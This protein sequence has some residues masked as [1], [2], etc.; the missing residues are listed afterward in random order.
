MTRH[1]KIATTG[2]WRQ[3]GVRYFC[4]SL[5]TIA[6]MSVLLV[7]VLDPALGAMPPAWGLLWRNA[8]PV[9]IFALLV[10]ALTGRTLFSVLLSAATVWA[11]YRTNAIKVVNLDEPLMPGD[12]V[13]VH[14]VLHNLGFF[15]H[16]T[17]HRPITLIAA[18][19]L[20]GLLMYAAW[21]VE[22]RCWRLRWHG[23][24][25]LT[26]LMLTALVTL[27]LGTRPWSAAYADEAMPDF[28]I[29]EPVASVQQVGLMAGLV[30]FSQ[31]AR[32]AVPMGDKR[33]VSDFAQSHAADMQARAS[34]KP[35]SQLPDVV[36][37]QSEA[38]FDPGVLKG[39]SMGEYAPNFERLAATGI[40]GS[41]T[42][43]TY[44][45]GTI[46]TEFETQTAYPMEAFPSVVYPYYGLASHWMP[47]LAHRLE[48]FGYSVSLFH[49]FKGSFWNRDTVMPELGFQH[50]HFEPDF[51][52]AQHA[53]VYVSDHAL[54]DHVLAHLDQDGPAPHYA[55]VITME[56]H[57]P[58]NL[59]PGDLV[60]DLK[61]HPLPAGLSAEGRKELTYYLAHLVNGDKALGDFAAKLMA[62]P[63]WTILIFYGDHL[64]ALTSAY[65]DLGFDDRGPDVGEHT[66]Y[67]LISNRP[68][69][70]QQMDLNSY[71][72]P[73]LLFDTIG[74]PE[75]GYLALA[76]ELRARWAAHD[77]QNGP[78]YGQIQFNAAELEVQ[79]RHKL[80]LTGKCKKW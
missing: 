35:P 34:R 65:A 61:A 57:G 51:A 42:T 44:G 10:Y 50:L 79:C 17:G 28:Q 9:A 63:R 1:A 55:F 21:R 27:F 43:P 72:L 54:F 13:L 40:S 59:D 32:I 5:L 37:V 64:P 47:T 15:S 16:Y 73:G 2:S 76:A 41:L 31:S 71:D 53:G 7:W 68:L 36:I 29:W 80:T 58:W 38:F 52:G 39:I 22:R 60:N 67:L 25:A 8:L 11:V 74:L 33:L 4:V 46:R 20:F 18:A 26:G 56:N 66:R 62:R 45:G 14:Q 70:P 24:I 19:V 49:P 3:R 6:L 23:R 75:D 30:K 48:A 12:L 77:F 78:H 69:Q